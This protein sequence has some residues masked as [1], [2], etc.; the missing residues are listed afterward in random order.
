[1]AA[2][3]RFLGLRISKLDAIEISQSGRTFK[4]DAAPAAV[5]RLKNMGEPG[6]VLPRFDLGDPRVCRSEIASNFQ[7]GNCLAERLL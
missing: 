2:M 6:S 4:C 5:T 1:M 7:P 3:A